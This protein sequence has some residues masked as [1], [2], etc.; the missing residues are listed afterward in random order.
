M[1]IAVRR[2]LRTAVG[3]LADR[4]TTRGRR[5][6]PAAAGSRTVLG[7]LFAGK[8]DVDRRRRREEHRPPRRRKCWR[9]VA[10]FLFIAGLLIGVACVLHVVIA[11]H[12]ARQ[13][14]WWRA[15]ATAAPPARGVVP[16]V[17][18]AAGVRVAALLLMAGAGRHQR[19]QPQ[20]LLSQSP[21]A[22]LSR[23]HALAPGERNP[24]NFTG[25]DDDDDLPLAIWSPAEPPRVRCTSSTAR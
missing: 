15:G 7:G 9:R 17:S 24:Q 3:G 2:G 25:F 10:P 11:D 19:V 5:C 22:L 16:G 6:R 20:R 8:S 4:R 1:V 14:D 21:G 13:L 23:R 12:S 18:L